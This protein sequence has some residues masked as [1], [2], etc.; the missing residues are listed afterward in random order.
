MAG[1]GARLGRAS[2]PVYISSWCD[3]VLRYK[4]SAH[5]AAR[6]LSFRDVDLAVARPIWLTDD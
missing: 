3:H 4:L 2:L 6:L 5:R 1:K